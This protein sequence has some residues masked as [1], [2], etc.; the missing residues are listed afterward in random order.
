MLLN[1]KLSDESKDYYIALS[2]TLLYFF[3]SN[4]LRY[5]K[6]F[7]DEGSFSIKKDKKNEKKEDEEGPLDIFKECIKFLIELI[8]NK[9]NEGLTYITQLYCI[10]YI[11]TFCYTFI[12]MHDN[13]EYNPDDV[14]KMINKYDKTN[15]V[16]LYVYKIIYN[17]NNKQINVFLNSDIKKKYK[18]NKY[19]EFNDFI[20]AEEIEKL[21]QFSYG[22]N[23]SNTLKILKEYEEN[24]FENEINKDDISSKKKRF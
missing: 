19:N 22:D 6:D 23:K 12:Q 9:I 11:K 13:K 20:K 10:G 24:H 5:L 15:M 1:K 4:S 21:E 14:I 3:E 8:N 17:K 2:E 18:L 7:L 16:K